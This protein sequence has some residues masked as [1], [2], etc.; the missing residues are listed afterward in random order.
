ANR[1][2]FNCSLNQRFEE[3]HKTTAR[4]RRPRRQPQTAPRRRR[5]RIQLRGRWFLRARLRLNLNKE[6]KAEEYEDLQL[7]YCPAVFTALE[8]YLPPNM[9]NAR[10]EHKVYALTA[11][12]ASFG[13]QIQPLNSALNSETN[14]HV[15]IKKIA[16]AFD[17]KIDAKRTL[18]EIKL[19][20]HMDHENL[21]VLEQHFSCS[22]SLPHQWKIW[23][24]YGC[25]NTPY[26]YLFV[27]I[28]RLIDRPEAF[29][30]G[31]F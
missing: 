4:R 29:V 16:N 9:L 22:S 5:R 28:L 17:N 24:P 1:G 2:V 13:K 23:N 18:R 25:S 3:C 27:A 19:L 6:H 8:R 26:G 7:M 15:A 11:L 12:M 14:E 21:S 10:R 31:I 30:S 20:R